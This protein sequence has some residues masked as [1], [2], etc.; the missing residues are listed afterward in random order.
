MANE[1]Y[2]LEGW[3]PA[4]VAANAPLVALV[5]AKVFEGRAPQK[6]ATF[7]PFR[8]VIFALL[9]GSTRLTMNGTRVMVAAKYKIVVADEDDFDADSY[10]AM[11]LL[12]TTFEKVD[13][14][15]FEG[16]VFN[17]RLDSLLTLQE[18]DERTGR[19]YKQKGGE[20]TVESYPV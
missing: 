2:K 12:V 1:L 7:N 17:S 11:N 4:M 20:F 8:C 10:T 3:I 19:V 14:N 15:V 6:T 5:G 13:T 16:N 18:T 9:D